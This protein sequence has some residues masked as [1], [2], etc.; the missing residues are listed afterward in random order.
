M[1]DYAA[2]FRRRFVRELW[3]RLGR[4][5][6]DRPI[7]LFGAGQHTD[8]LLDVVSDVERGPQV[9]MILDDSSAR[10][11]IAD[12]PVLR[13]DDPRAADSAGALSFVVVSS[14][15]APTALAERARGWLASLPSSP[16]AEVI[17]P[18]R[19]LPPGPYPSDAPS[20]R[21]LEVERT[22]PADADTDALNRA[23]ALGEP[24]P[25]PAS[26]NRAGYAPETDAEYISMGR[27][28][29][30]A[31]RAVLTSHG[32]DVERATD[33]LD[34]GCSTGRV[35]RHFLDVPSRP[36]L[37]GC[38]ID[39]HAIEWGQR[40]LGERLRLF[41]STL[42]PRLPMPDASFDIVYGISVFTHISHNIDTWLAELRRVTRPGGALLMTVHDE[43]T[44]SLCAQR[45]DLYI[46][47]QCPRFDFSKPLRDDFRSHGQGPASQTFWHAD[48]IRRRWS[49][50]F[51]I[52]GFERLS[53]CSG[54]QTGVVLRPRA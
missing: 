27:A 40:H 11:D 8:W 15:A 17:E 21:P 33:V 49:A 29:A 24:L 30:N 18:Y 3:R 48:G 19:G 23:D 46:T 54:M 14:D 50:F 26:S 43:Q 51:E 4:D 28:E 2:H 42:D 39:E 53:F 36:T 12:V 25:V 9:A 34:W 7:A 47:K 31:I 6:G 1:I 16:R 45:P 22:I 52:V 5:A 41:Q 38:D 20:D 10:S 13:P 37:W 32:V 44:W 35:L